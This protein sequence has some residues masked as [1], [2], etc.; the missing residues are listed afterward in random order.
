[1]DTGIEAEHPEFD[2]RL[3]K[4]ID[5]TGRHGE[6]DT[7]RH[8]HGPAMAGITAA[9]SNNGEG[10][11]GIADK[12]KIRSIRI[13]IHGRGITAVQLV[14]AWEAVL[15]CG[16]SDIIVYAY[17]G[18]VCRRTASIYNYVLKKAVKKD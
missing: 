9:N 7:D 5:L 8:G 10:I 12:V 17:A 18:G 3:L 11:S 4:E 1:M 16:D 2:R 14:R 6:N 13:S 15:A